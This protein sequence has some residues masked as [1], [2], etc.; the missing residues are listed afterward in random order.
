MTNHET[1]KHLRDAQRRLRSVL[2]A[3]ADRLSTPFTDDPSK[4]PWD[5]YLRPAVRGL[6]EA[7]SAACDALA[8]A[9]AVSVPPPAPRADDRAAVLREAADELGRMDYD[10]DSHDYG[11]DTYRD[12]WNG[13]V[14]D[15]ADLLR[16]LADEAPTEDAAPDGAL[17][18][19]DGPVRCPL[20]VHTVTLHTPNGA[21]AHFAAI[22]PERRLTGRGHGPWPLLVTDGAEA[23]SAVSGPCVAG[24]Q[25]NET[26]EAEQPARPECAHC[27]RE[28]ENRGT[29]NM[30]GPSRDNWVHVPGGFTV[31][32]PQR[33]ADSPRAEPRA[34][35]V[36]E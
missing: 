27:W 15:G 36:P 1:A 31:C 3:N 17:D 9:A 8:A 32:F 6:Q 28:I 7:V 35:E 11:Y 25:Q 12:A 26:P 13:G 20:C 24:E 10:T 34:V 18:L 29:P 30:G 33:G 19:A 23:Q 14:M 2:V 16:R 21:R 4:N 22:H 5:T